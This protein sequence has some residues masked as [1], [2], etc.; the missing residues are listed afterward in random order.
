[1][2]VEMWEVVVCV[3]GWCGDRA[4]DAQPPGSPN[5]FAPRDVPAGERVTD[6][7][8]RAHDV[9]RLARDDRGVGR[10]PAGCRSPVGAACD[11][12]AGRVACH[13]QAIDAARHERLLPVVVHIRQ[14]HL[15]PRHRRVDVA[16]DR[17]PIAAHH[18]PLLSRVAM[19]RVAAVPII[20]NATTTYCSSTVTG[21]VSAT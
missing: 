21:T 8:G 12:R 3:G 19:A 10:R 14:Q 16:V 7:E 2:G 6:G 5:P 11:W 20:Y 15:D 9:E 18:V 1:G 13:L 17:T 4:V